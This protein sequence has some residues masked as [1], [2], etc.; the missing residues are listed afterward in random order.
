MLDACCDEFTPVLLDIFSRCVAGR[1]VA[2]R[3]SK[4][5]ARKLIEE[6][7]RKLGIASV[8]SRYSPLAAR[9]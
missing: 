8:S 5:L 3:E 4:Q 6:T 1:M 7:V 9:R 2:E